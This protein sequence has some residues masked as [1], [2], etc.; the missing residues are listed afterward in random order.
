MIVVHCPNCES[1]HVK[2]YEGKMTEKGHDW[3][4]CNEC[5]ENFPLRRSS[6]SVEADIYE[7]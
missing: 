4:H 6:Y 1:T 3:F 7:S 5:K 2:R